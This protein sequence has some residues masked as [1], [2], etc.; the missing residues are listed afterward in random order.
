MKIEE[1]DDLGTK[2]G[3]SLGRKVEDTVNAQTKRS[4]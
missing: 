4:L 3:K 2:F 1:G